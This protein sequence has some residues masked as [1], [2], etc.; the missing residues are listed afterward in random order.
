MRK[1]WTSFAFC[2]LLS[3]IPGQAFSASKCASDPDAADLRAAGEDPENPAGAPAKDVSRPR[4]RIGTCGWGTELLRTLRAGAKLLSLPNGQAYYPILL[5]D[6]ESGW[7]CNHLKVRIACI[8]RIEP[9]AEGT[10]VTLTS[11]PKPPYGVPPETILVSDGGQVRYQNNL[12][13]F[14]LVARTNKKGNDIGDQ[15]AQKAEGTPCGHY[16]PCWKKRLAVAE[17]LMIERIRAYRQGQVGLSH[18]ERLRDAQTLLKDYEDLTGDKLLLHRAII[19]NEIG[20]DESHAVESPFALSDAVA[21][22]S[23]PSFGAHQIDVGT[24]LDAKKNE[25]SERILFRRVVHTQLGSDR[26]PGLRRLAAP[27]RANVDTAKG[28][29]EKP[30]R[31][32]DIRTFAAFYR[33]MP[34]ITRDLRTDPRRREYYALYNRFLERGAGCMASLRQRGGIFATSGFA[35]VYVIDVKNQFGEDVAVEAARRA[36]RGGVEKMKDY[37]RKT[38]FGSRHLR[39]INE[40]ISN[41]EK[42]AKRLPGQGGGNPRQCDMPELRRL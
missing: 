9:V 41:I 35:R 33:A 36:I 21:G 4:T 3:L 32:Y 42:L 38:N 27:A 39:L 8:G 28:H 18:E 24:K 10:R 14:M 16:K 2:A 1:L 13:H 17:R 37:V 29:L 19:L 15:I 7:R 6:K 22:A 20:V 31:E 26:D 12:G 11:D 5:T 40:R 25:S 30:I 34:L 23:G